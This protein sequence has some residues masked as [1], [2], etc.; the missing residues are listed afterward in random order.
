MAEKKQAGALGHAA[1]DIRVALMTTAAA[2]PEPE[3]RRGPAPQQPRLVLRSSRTDATRKTI[4]IRDGKIEIS[5]RLPEGSE[6]EAQTLLDLYRLQKGAKE[7]GI[8]APR[9]VPVAAV[10]AHLLE[11]AR[12]GRN[13]TD[14]E[15]VTYSALT[16]RLGTLARYFGAKVLKDV[17]T[18]ECKLYIEWRTS[19]PDARYR[20]GAP[21]APLAKVASAREDLFELRKA[22]RL[23]ADE[24][25][26]AWHPNVHVPKAGPGRT[27]WLRR[28]EV[29]RILWAIRGR[30]WDPATNTW[31]VETVTGPDGVTVT[32]HVLRPRHMVLNRRMLRRFVAVGLYTGT[33]NTASRELSWL[34]S[35]DGGCLDLD[36]CFIHRRGFGRDPKEGKPRASSRLARKFAA[37]AIPWRDADLA[38][39]ITHVIHRPDGSAYATSP[40]C[41][42]DAVIAD[43]G[44]GKEVVPHVLRHTAA[45]WLR[46]GRTDVR[47]A[48]DLLGM[49]VQAAVRIYGQW[50]LE[51]QDT[52]A[53]ELGYGKGLKADVFVGGKT[54]KPRPRPASEARPAPKVEPVPV[55]APVPVPVFVPRRPTMPAAAQIEPAQPIFAAKLPKDDHM[56]RDRRRRDRRISRERSAKQLAYLRRD[57]LTLI[58]R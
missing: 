57:A 29:A 58:K 3:R 56:T 21:D 35:E 13:A 42:W 30:V 11:A 41:I 51:G 7:R 5:T 4:Y 34:A 1:E 9:M 49:S 50:T 38:F 52:A 28:S 31:M 55:V 24:H 45:T 26:L 33:R 39:G 10:L 20:E 23:Y 27:R 8:V 6:S 46:V 16:T 14:A 53:D 32:R 17:T 47:A 18:A 12:P 43:A 22:V 37:M 44:L 2:L 25:A 36:G 15:K 48:A 19:L 54:R 40:S